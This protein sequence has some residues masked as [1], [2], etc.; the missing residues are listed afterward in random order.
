MNECKQSGGKALQMRVLAVAIVPLALVA[1]DAGG[2]VAITDG[3][4]VIAVGVDDDFDDPFFDPRDA[5][6]LL[7]I[8]NSGPAAVVE[9]NNRRVTLDDGRLADVDR[10]SAPPPIAPP[11]G[12]DI[13]Y[14]LD[15]TTDTLVGVNVE[16]I[17]G[18]GNDLDVTA[19]G[20]WMSETRVVDDFLI[21]GRTG[22]FLF[23][24]ST[25]S[26][27]M[28]TFGDA[29]YEGFATAIE[30]SP[31][32]RSLLLDGPG[33]L[34]ANFNSRRI[35]GRFDIDS[36]SGSWGRIDIDDTAINGNSFRGDTV[37]TSR[38]HAGTVSGIFLGS[39]AGEIGGVLELED[40]D[41]RQLLGAF[42]ARYQR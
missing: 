23:G 27:E 24:R 14:L 26:S 20:V 41:G 35:D 7:S 4:T 15:T 34:E 36:A 29:T 13:A 12:S 19:F 10:N 33:R 18:N 40:T 16:A 6:A 37:T 32:G 22:A 11:T 3:S 39:R 30:R 25:R 8:A 2:G 31:D 42:G 38:G 28:P 9:V 21:S 17:G 1:C 5:D